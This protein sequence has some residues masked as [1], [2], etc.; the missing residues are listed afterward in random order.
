MINLTKKEIMNISSFFNLGKVLSYKLIKGGLVNYNY[1][2]KTPK[3]NYIFRIVGNK[4]KRK[5]NHLS[6]QFKIV[7]Y[8]VRKKFPYEVPIPIKTEDNKDLIKI[9]GDYYVWAYKMLEG[10]SYDRPSILQIK[11]MA[12]ALAT[13]HRFIQGFKAKRYKEEANKRIISGLSKIHKIVAKTDVDKFGLKY[14]NHFESMFNKVKNID[15]SVNEL[16][17]HSDFDA[18]NV[19]FDKGK[20]RAIID[21]DELHYAPRV[22]DVAISIRDSCCT[23]GNLDMDKVRIFLKEYCNVIKL[24]K[25][26]KEMIIPIILNASVDFYVWILVKMKKE[27]ENKKKYLKEMF[28]LTEDIIKNNKKIS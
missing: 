7:N 26:E 21:F 16:F 8:L 15:L 23:R 19:L 24:S 27:P 1:V 4:D 14:L 18:S 20:L 12:F 10:K 25:K 11:P 22:F 3:G 6:L 9:K 28:V 13:Y 17:V 2:I 5:L